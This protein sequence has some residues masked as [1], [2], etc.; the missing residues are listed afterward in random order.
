MINLLPPE[1]HRAVK[2]E[3]FFRTGASLLLLF[4]SVGIFLTAA[5]IPTYV[6]VGAQIK[7]FEGTHGDESNKGATTTTQTD[8]RDTEDILKQL[9]KTGESFAVSSLIRE[10]ET[11]APEGILF[12]T[13]RIE[14]V[15]VATTTVQVQG[16]AETRE[17]LARFKVALET[18]KSFEK[19]EVPISNLAKEI[20]LPFGI[21]ITTKKQK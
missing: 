18:S 5:F 14:S 15:S 1:G 13:F 8:I 19:A 11:L 2:Q 9:G 10:I 6:L 21:T 3:Y 7:S 4:S 17:A 12:K 20:D 16:I